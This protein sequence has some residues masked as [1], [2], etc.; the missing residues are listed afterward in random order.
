MDDVQQ[1][2]AWAIDMFMGDT[3][4]TEIKKDAE[5]AYNK[6]SEENFDKEIEDVYINGYVEARKAELDTALSIANKK[7]K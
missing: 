1:L 4:P 5:D 3:I 2:I 6:Y 7:E